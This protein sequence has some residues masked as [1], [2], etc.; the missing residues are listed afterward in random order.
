MALQDSPYDSVLKQN[1]FPQARKPLVF[2]TFTARLKSCPDTKQEFCRCP[3]SRA[4]IQSVS[5]Q[6]SLRDYPS[7]IRLPRI[8]SW[9]KV[10][11]PFGTF[12]S[13]SAAS[14]VVP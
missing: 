9:A 2:S 5:L 4:L 7:S 8:T 10:S 6:P 1:H 11:R 13:F 3:W 14:K 12:V